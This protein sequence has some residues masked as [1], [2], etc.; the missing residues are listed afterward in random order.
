MSRSSFFQLDRE[1]FCSLAKVSPHNVMFYDM[2]RGQ[3]DRL[4]C[5]VEKQ[6]Q[7][8]KTKK[9]KKEKEQLKFNYE[10]YK[11]KLALG[12][13]QSNDT[14]FNLLS[15]VQQLFGSFSSY[16]VHLPWTYC[17]NKR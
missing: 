9:Q 7:K 4:L 1:A 13:S 17:V 2:I 16:C 14:A 3:C 5:S 11:Q 12:T 6:K 15:I 8:K 10:K